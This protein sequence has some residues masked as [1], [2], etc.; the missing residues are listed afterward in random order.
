MAL[1]TSFQ[2]LPDTPESVDHSDL[3]ILSSLESLTDR[4]KK[5]KFQSLLLNVEAVLEPET[6]QMV[7]TLEPSSQAFYDVY[8]YMESYLLP[9]FK[10]FEAQ[11]FAKNADTLL[12]EIK[13]K[14]SQEIISTIHYRERKDYAKNTE[15][16]LAEL[17]IEIEHDFPE[18]INFKN[19]S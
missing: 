5:V 12:G 8:V 19:F 18:K 2:N 13:S 7:Q 14:V 9:K 15:P 3:E 11:A 4:E 10:Q 1:E 16:V 6:L 17:K